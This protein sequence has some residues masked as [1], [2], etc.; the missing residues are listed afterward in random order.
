MSDFNFFILL[1][2]VFIAVEIVAAFGLL[3]DRGQ[4]NPTSGDG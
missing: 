4:S 3:D 2:V 1:A